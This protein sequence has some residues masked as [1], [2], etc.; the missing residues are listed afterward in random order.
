MTTKRTQFKALLEQQ[1][2]LRKKKQGLR[3]EYNE[4]F[5][6]LL[7]A[8]K[9]WAKITDSYKLRNKAQRALT[10]D[11]LHWLQYPLVAKYTRLLQEYTEELNWINVQLD[12]LAQ[13]LIPKTGSLWT[14][15]RTVWGSTYNTQGFGANAY[16][17]GAAQNYALNFEALGLETRVVEIKKPRPKVSYR[18]VGGYIHT[19][20]WEVQVK[21]SYCDI[22]I[23][24]RKPALSLRDWVK[25]CWAKQL[26]PRVFD[27]W[28]PHDLEARLG[29]D[30][31]GRDVAPRP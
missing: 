29:I 11:G 1:S 19:S 12:R 13:T 4:E 9:P 24:K 17:R 2:T 20:D 23:A 8:H 10:L 3:Q 7:R 5:D 16:A 26:N 25:A 15:V 28:L 31:Q 27:P 21:A 6:A 22:E 14:S 30:Y 18:P